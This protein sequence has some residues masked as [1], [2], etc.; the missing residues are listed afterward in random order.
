MVDSEQ[1]KLVKI[2]HSDLKRFLNQRGNTPPYFIVVHVGEN[3]VPLGL[4]FH[5][6]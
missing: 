3:S 5:G 2:Y 6:H 1:T 4:G